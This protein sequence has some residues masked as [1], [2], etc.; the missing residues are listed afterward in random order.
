MKNR[1]KIPIQGM[2]CTS[3]E[4]LIEN[5]LKKLHGI[6]VHRVS[7]KD[8]EIEFTHSKGF[9]LEKLNDVVA[10]HGYKIGGGDTAN[11]KNDPTDYIEM[12]LILGLFIVAAWILDELNLYRFFPQVGDGA[13]AIVALLLGL[14]ASVSTCLALVGGL[15]ISFG[16]TYKIDDD[17]AHPIFARMKPHF[18]FHAGRFGAFVLLG[19]LLGVAG[20][21]FSFSLS[22]TSYLTFAVAMVMFYIGLQILGILPNITKLGFR[23]PKRL[24]SRVGVLQE[25]EHA[26]APL[27]LG[28]VTF[29]LPCGFTQSAQLAAIGSQSFAGGVMMMGAF[30]LGTFP[31]LFGIGVGSTYAKELK[32]KTF[33]KFIGVLIVL[34]AVFSFNN[35][36]RL[37]GVSFDFT[38]SQD[39]IEVVLS[40]DGF[41]EI[42]MTANWG[43]EPN[44]FVIQKD[45][46]VR[47]IIEGENVSGCINE[48]VIPELGLSRKLS[49]GENII[50][51][52]PD[53]SGDM[54]FSCW[55]GMVGG[56]F[57]VI[58]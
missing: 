5:D 27:F 44:E 40:E 22:F 53:E 57:T 34:F 39:A 6:I 12:L 55:M 15:V 48:I 41:Q 31:V 23:M 58:Q 18:L 43:Y 56:K 8:G 36:L 30:A 2:H 25:A 17:A 50:E 20:S 38:S 11:E 46:P 1:K 24:S 9:K 33:K 47:W 26:F 35:G 54:T 51:F 45:I 14:V 7:H 52:T 28:A 29:F 4:I 19:G 21:F 37:M 10:K 49:K 42:Y 16:S 13:S 3:C 32:A